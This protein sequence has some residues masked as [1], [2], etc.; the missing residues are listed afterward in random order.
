MPCSQPR[1]PGAHS[2]ALSYSSPG[3]RAGTWPESRNTPEGMHKDGCLKE[4]CW[5]LVYIPR[6][7]GDLWPTQVGAG[8]GPEG[9]EFFSSSVPS[10]GG[11][12][13]MHF[14]TKFYEEEWK[15]RKRWSW[16]TCLPPSD[17]YL[18]SKERRCET[19]DT[20]FIKIS[21]LTEEGRPNQ[22]AK[23]M[24]QFISHSSAPSLAWGRIP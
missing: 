17:V 18:C 11:C 24:R 10:G 4:E 3:N 15:G 21:I 1:C 14:R 19:G 20:I 7:L 12:W 8:L 5:L 22:R 6:G 16:R 13:C 9:P 23:K 2:P